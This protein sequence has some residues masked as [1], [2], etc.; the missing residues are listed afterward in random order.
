MSDVRKEWVA[1]GL[2]MTWQTSD[3]DEKYCL[4][5]L[6]HEPSDLAEVVGFLRPDAFRLHAHQAVFRALLELWQGGTPIDPA[7]VADLLHRQGRLPDLG[8]GNKA[9]LF[10]R[11]L[12]LLPVAPGSAPVHAR[13]VRDHAIFRHLEGAACAILQEARE[14]TG[15]ASEVLQRA[16]RA[17]YAISELGAEGNAVPLSEAI[18]QALEEIERRQAQRIQRGSIPGVPSGLRI[19]DELTAGWHQGEL[20]ILAARPSVGKT[21]LSL[22]FALGAAEGGNTVL[23]QSLEQRAAELAQRILCGRSGVQADLCRRGMLSP[24]H[25]S[26]LIDAQQIIAPLPLW[27]DDS[28]SQTLLRIAANARRFS[29]RQTLSLLIIDY[30]QLIEPENQRAKRHEQ[31]A[32]LSRGLKQLARELRIPVICLAQLN[33]EVENR[34]DK[35]PKLADLRESGSIEQDADTVILLHRPSEVPHAL[36]LLIAK[37]RNGPIGE[38]RVSFDRSRMRFEDGSSPHSSSPSGYDPFGEEGE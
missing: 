2:P 34:A 33:R 29:S 7:N 6:L 27:V 36:D 21:A 26:R 15:S 38:V 9:Y 37:Q 18:Y 13:N 20:T 17:V 11:E 22:S 1:T 30:L 24:E 4:G 35:K 10:L 28:P 8:E 31:V 3:R 25:A 23:Y 19:L 12:W 14:P 16:E 5:A 32:E